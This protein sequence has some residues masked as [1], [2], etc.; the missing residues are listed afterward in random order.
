[1]RRA[2]HSRS[3]ALFLGRIDPYWRSQLLGEYSK[4]LGSC[5]TLDDPNGD[6]RYMVDDMV[7]HSYDI[8]FLTRDSSLQEKLLHAAHEDF[9]SMHF[10]AYIALEDFAWE[11]IQCDIFQ[12]MER[13]IAQMMIERM[14]QAPSYSLGVRENFRLSHFSSRP[15]VHDG[16]GILLHFVLY[17]FSLFD[18][19]DVGMM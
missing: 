16:G 10:D 12:H 19:H 5:M 4:D 9:F 6:D 8:Y 18:Q 15:Q 13:C 1:M 2:S 3:L 17:F 11:G 14:S 7:I